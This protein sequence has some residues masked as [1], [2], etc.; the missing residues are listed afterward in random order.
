MDKIN[1]KQSTW[2]VFHYFSLHYNPIYRDKY[3]DFFKTFQVILPCEMCLKHYRYQLSRHDLSLEE[4]I[5]VEKI[6]AWTVKIHNHVN[7]ITQKRVWA[8]DEAKDFYSRQNFNPIMLKIMILDYIKHNFKKRMVKSTE[9]LKML[10]TLRYLYP[11]EEKRQ[12][13]LEMKNEL[14]KETIREWLLEFFKIIL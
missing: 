13:L 14:K 5:N 6:F 11:I 1:W 7:S 3:I 12:K 8:V 4:N 10:D 2:Y 9:L